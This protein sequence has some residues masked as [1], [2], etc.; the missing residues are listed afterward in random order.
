MLLRFVLFSTHPR[1]LNKSFFFLIT[2]LFQCQS[3]PLVLSQHK[4]SSPSLS[5]VLILMSRQTQTS[6]EC[7]TSTRF[8]CWMR[9]VTHKIP[10]TSPLLPSIRLHSS[11]LHHSSCSPLSSATT[12]THKSIPIGTDIVPLSQ[13]KTPVTVL[14]QNI[15]FPDVSLPYVN[16][17][18]LVGDKTHQI[19]TR[20]VSITHL[21]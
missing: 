1:C 15:H 11:R 16:A 2:V 14:L 4:M 17:H 7:W 18:L 20:L 5:M 3:P 9:L 21:L 10:F 8:D 12:T 6:T 19:T 13:A